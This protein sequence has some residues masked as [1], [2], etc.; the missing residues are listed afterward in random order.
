M[1]GDAGWVNVKEICYLQKKKKKKKKKK[2]ERE[3]L[4]LEVWKFV[5]NF[6]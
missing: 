3:R 4:S 2:T 5:A 1:P 6:C